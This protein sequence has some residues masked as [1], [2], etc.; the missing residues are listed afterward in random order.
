MWVVVGACL[1]GGG[2]WSTARERCGRE[3]GEEGLEAG[4]DVDFYS[5]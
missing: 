5:S 4:M 1:A 2:G 3:V